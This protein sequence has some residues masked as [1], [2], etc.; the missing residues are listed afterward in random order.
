MKAISKEK[1]ESFNRKITIA[2][3]V[4]VLMMLIAA[5]GLIAKILDYTIPSA[6]R[7]ASSSNKLDSSQVTIKGTLECLQ[8]KEGAPD[9]CKIGIKD[10]NGDYYAISGGSPL[11][12]YAEAGSKH[13]EISGNITPASSND[14]YNIKGVI[15]RP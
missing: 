10:L 7:E 5:S 2:L 3:V 14:K 4:C 13:V 1:R 15:N 6:R 8:V 12:F 11:E 9:S